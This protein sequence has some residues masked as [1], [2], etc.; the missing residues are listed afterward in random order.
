MIRSLL[1]I[2][3]LSV[4]AE[5]RQLTDTVDTDL[6][7]VPDA[8]ILDDQNSDAA[9]VAVLD[10]LEIHPLDVNTCSANEF[11]QIPDIDAVLAESIVQTRL[12]QRF[13]KIADLAMVPGLSAE[14][15]RR[16]G[17]YLTIRPTEYAKSGTVE[18][19]LRGSGQMSDAENAR[20]QAR[21]RLRG[22]RVG[23]NAIQLD[24]IMIG[25]GVDVPQHAFR[26]PSWYTRISI[27]TYGISVLAGDFGM[28]AGRGL[29]LWRVFSRDRSFG[30]TA[31]GMSARGAVP[32]S[33]ALRTGTLR[34]CALEFHAGSVRSAIF[35]SRRDVGARISEDDGIVSLS[36]YGISSVS[37]TAVR[38][39]QVRM[40]SLGGFC[41]AAVTDWFAIETA[42][43]TTR[44]PERCMIIN[45]SS[46]RAGSVGFRLTGSRLRVSGEYA[47][48]DGGRGGGTIALWLNASDWCTVSIEG[49]SYGDGFVSIQGNAP[50]AGRV[51]GQRERGVTTAADMR[52]HRAVTALFRVDEFTFGAPRTWNG[53]PWAGHDMLGDIG[54]TVARSTRV[55][56]QARL[57]VIQT[58][59][60]AMEG[61]EVMDRR[62]AQ[63]RRT[64][65]WCVRHTVRDMFS[66]ETR[67]RWS[68]IATEGTGS[69]GSGMLVRQEIS[70]RSGGWLVLRSGFCISGV[71]DEG[72]VLYD[73]EQGVPGETELITMSGDGTRWYIGARCQLGGGLELS[74]KYVQ[75]EV[76]RSSAGPIY[77]PFGAHDIRSQWRVQAEGVIGFP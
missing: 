4:T 56:L 44:L 43:C 66:L 1:C 67:V 9:A 13:Q 68:G 60:E 18:V 27:P 8:D 26:D 39:T 48:S 62:Y 63:S 64:F 25:D 20:S 72:V 16:I 73:S 65:Q 53:L 24:G 54:I 40:E 2:A 22:V 28:E 57:R 50:S 41:A 14:R 74:A 75:N 32:S 61:T 33:S 29:V 10:D 70:W 31:D 17:R 3:L 34:G 46:A 52:V 30:P 21:L 69:R 7:L 42:L 11:M 55:R 51:Q 58:T 37:R 36:E 6:T 47:Q 15:V 76:S 45:A 12:E 59:R 23:D 19:R 71:R 77:N 38:S 49:R 5:A 35:V